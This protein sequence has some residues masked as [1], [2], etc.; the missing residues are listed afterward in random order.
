MKLSR[1]KNFILM[2][3]NY[4]IFNFMITYKIKILKKEKGILNIKLL[5]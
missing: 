5:N 4:N 2:L 1:T 3:F